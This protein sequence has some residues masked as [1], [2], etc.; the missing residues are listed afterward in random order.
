MSRMTDL[1]MSFPL[2]HNRIKTVINWE[3]ELNHCLALIGNQEERLFLEL[4]AKTKPL[5]INDLVTLHSFLIMGHDLKESLETMQNGRKLAFHKAII[6]WAFIN[7][8]RS[9]K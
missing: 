4:Y 5:K 8:K 3:R 6:A 7:A 1:I 2:D 9:Q